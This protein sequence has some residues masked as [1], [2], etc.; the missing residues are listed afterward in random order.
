MWNLLELLNKKKKH[1]E[2]LKI[3]Y[4]GFR[5]EFQKRRN[6]PTLSCSLKSNLPCAIIGE[7]KLASPSEGD[8]GRSSS[9][10]P[11]VEAYVRGGAAAISVVTEPFYFKG[12]LA[13]LREV[14]RLS[15]LPVL[16]KDFIVDPIE[17]IESKANGADAV[18]LI[19]SVLNGDLLRDLINMAREL[20]LETLVEVHTKEELFWAMEAGARVIGINNRDLRSLNVDLSISHQIADSVPEDVILVSE[21]G[22]KEAR[23]IL[24]L[25]KSGIYAFLI[26]TA[27]MRSPDPEKTLFSLMDPFSKMLRSKGPFVKI[28]GITNFYDAL[29]CIRHGAEFLGF[30]FSRGPRKIS[31]AEL[32][33]INQQV[34]EEVPKIAV[35]HR[36]QLRDWRS[37]VSLGISGLQVHKDGIDD[38]SSFLADLINMGWQRP[39][40]IPSIPCAKGNEPLPPVVKELGRH[41]SILHG[42]SGYGGGTGILGDW[43]KAK[44]ITQLI[45]SSKLMLAGGLGP[46]N[47]G[48]AI[49]H[50][51][52]W[53]VDVSSGV[54]SAWGKKD[55]DKVKAFI[56]GAKGALASVV[57]DEKGYFGR[58]GGRFVPELIMPALIELEE[59]YREITKDSTYQQRLAELYSTYVGRPT[60]LYYAGRLSREWGAE[61]LLKRE[62]LTHTGAHKINNTIG[63]ALLAKFMGKT[64][65]IAETGAG[66]HGVAVATVCALLG[67][68]C[69]IYMGSQDVIRQRPN[70]L[71]MRLLGAQVIPVDAGSATLK[72]AINEAMRDWAANLDHSYYLIGSVVGP[73]PYPMMVRDFQSIIGKEAREQVQGMFGRL[74]DALVACV[75]GGSNA[76]GLFYPFIED[77]EVDMYGVEA[78]GKGIETQYHASTL[79][80]GKPGILHGSLTYVLQDEWGQ[81]KDAHSIA[82]GLDYPGVGPEHSFLKEVRRVRYESVKDLEAV[83]AFFELSSKEG[84]IP[85][86]ESSHAIAF[87]KRLSKEKKGS[88][89][90]VNLSGRGDKDME[91]IGEIS[92]R[93]GIH[94][95]DPDGL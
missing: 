6:R 9:L 92:G 28:C 94:G 62:D 20:D 22:I 80:G 81:I 3:R 66:Q 40:I 16:R 84:I 58:F 11:L 69:V 85:A 65:I 7:I 18:L 71:K 59:A 88:V 73:H 87:S 21:S 75:G 90:L 74:P 29:E 53:A 13:Y 86:L 26:G 63:Q 38:V 70:V 15:P 54:E 31:L 19:A 51:S 14:S 72:D 49:R 55:K 60:P 52:P 78:G 77:K 83:E 10:R 33:K 24:D 12:D 1:L 42:D 64:R 41:F 56:R 17:L 2:E 30:V 43:D 91:I 82:P 68:E 89:I 93:G 67:L 44:A 35:I 27:L 39:L 36:S 37:F 4:G 32:E 46:H 23:D 79:T 61:I 95:Q 34:P 76:M 48:E 8:L 25:K 45:P 47:V 5:P 50:V 57:P